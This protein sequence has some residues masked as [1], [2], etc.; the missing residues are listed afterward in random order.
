[1]LHNNRLSRAK[2]IISTKL[3]SY[4]YKYISLIYLPGVSSMPVTSQVCRNCN[5]SFPFSNY[6]K[7]TTKTRHGYMT[8]CKKCHLAS[9]RRRASN[10]VSGDPRARLFLSS[11]V[12]ASANNIEHTITLSDIELPKFCKY[13]N[14]ELD[15]REANVR[16]SRLP[17]DCPSI[18]RIDPTKGYIPGNIQVISNLAN[19]MKNNASV[20]QLITF[21]KN[22][23]AIHDV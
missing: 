8:V 13:L 11:Y 18:D 1:M 20:E 2:T 4:I 23:L 9:C 17:F 7:T 19:R 6:Y 16:K 3:S 22:V 15:Y 14:I 5:K 21:A 12:R 10:K